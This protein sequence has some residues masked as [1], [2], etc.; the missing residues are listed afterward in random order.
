MSTKRN[1]ESLELSDRL[2]T[3]KRIADGKQ[4]EDEELDALCL[5]INEAQQRLGMLDA[6]TT[7]GLAVK[8]ELLKYNLDA[9]TPA[10]LLLSEVPSKDTRH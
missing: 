2:E 1:D 9:N 6:I 3:L 10:D 7:E 8:V 4:I 5:S